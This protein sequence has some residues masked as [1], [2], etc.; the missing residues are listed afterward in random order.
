MPVLLMRLAGPLQ[1]WGER[2]RFMVRSTAAQPTKSGVVGLLASALGRD[3]GDDV[4]DLAALEF[5]ARLDR[6]GRVVVDFQTAHVWPDPEDVEAWRDVRNPHKPKNMPKA[7]PMPLSHRFYLADACF[8]VAVGGD[9]VLLDACDE[10][11]RH[12][13][14]APYLGRRSCPADV[15]LTL[16]VDHSATDVRDVLRSVPW[17]GGLAARRNEVP[18]EYLEV[19]CDARPGEEAAYYADDAPITF[20]PACRRFSGRAAAR[21]VVP[22]PGTGDGARSGSWGAHSALGRRPGPI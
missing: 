8:L 5:A 7:A 19:V 13:A 9:G 18:P 3:R 6:P 11:L 10:A 16:G 4:S 15:P 1:S 2:S 17:L 12:P 20:D 14:R 21:V 22:V